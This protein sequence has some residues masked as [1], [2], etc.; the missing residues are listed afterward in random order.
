MRILFNLAI[1]VLVLTAAFSGSALAQQPEQKNVFKE[2]LFW[3][4]VGAASA[5]CIA[6][7]IVIDGK[8]VREGNPLF[9]DAD[10]TV[11]WQ[12]AIIGKVAVVGIPALVYKFN[13]RWGRRLMMSS[14]L[15]H[16]GATG[17]TVIIGVKYR[18]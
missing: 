8:R 1:L 14:V 7:R 3:L 13:P 12:R 5:D 15:W 9:L 4:N 10:G 17:Y 18:W 2:K 16:F 6:S 11:N